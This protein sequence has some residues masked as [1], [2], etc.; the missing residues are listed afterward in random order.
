MRILIPLVA[1]ASL[2]LFSCQKEVDFA[3]NNG[4]GGNGGNTSGTML[5][6]IVQKN[7]S[8][9]LV[10]SY[11]YNSD[12]KIINLKIA[13][14]DSGTQQNTEYRYYRNASG[15]VTHYSIIDSS[16]AASGI[17][18]IVT[19][20]HYNSSTSRYTGYVINVN[21]SGFILLDSAAYVYDGSGKIIE[22]D[23]YESP[24][25]TGTDYY[26]SG[27]LNYSYVNGNISE[28]DIHDFD[29]SG[30]ET[31]TASNKITYDSKTNSFSAGNEG[32]PLGHPEWV[33]VNNI[34]G[35]QLSD[36]NGP[37]DDQTVS[38]NYAYGSNNKPQTAVVSVVPGNSVFN[39]SYYYQ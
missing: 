20:V 24:T 18:S 6:K 37:A 31:F 22:E 5:V 30:T 7:G 34:A 23:L 12:K 26:F 19:V 10:S 32:F 4:N 15:I 39:F 27:K 16:L 14:V 25:G 13:G 38:Y 36:S 29:Q 17:D 21:V 2:C 1:F 9:S 28:L 33:S 3:N 35:E 8:D 11:A